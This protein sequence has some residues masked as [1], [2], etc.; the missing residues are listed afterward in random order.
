MVASK[1]EPESVALTDEDLAILSK[2]SPTVVGHVGKVMVVGP[3]LLTDEL[4][5]SLE[6]RIGALPSLTRRLGGPPRAPAWVPDAAF[7]LEDHIVEATSP[8]PLTNADLNQQIAELFAQRLDRSRPLWRIDVLGPLEDGSQVLVWRVHH[9][10]ADGQTAVRFATALL[11]DVAT[12]PAPPASAVRQA[13]ENA[14][15]HHRS[16]RQNLAGF[17]EREFRREG[18]PSPFDGQIGAQRSVA[19]ATVQL[20]PLRR[21]ARSVA[22]ATVND[23]VLACVTGGLRRWMAEGGNEPLQDLRCKVPVSM[24]DASDTLGNRDSFFYL[25]LPLGEPDPAERLRLIRQESAIRKTE[26]DAQEIDRALAALSR[27]SPRLRL[28]CDRF[29]M[30]PRE[31]ALNVSNVPGPR[32][33]VSVVGQPV[34]SIHDLADIAERHALRVAAVS[35]AG[36]LGFGLCADASLIEDLPGLADAIQAEAADLIAIAPPS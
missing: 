12:G 14:E 3:T 16:H 24:H 27:A 22:G 30:D 32:T 11:W 29:L 9:A 18:G 36:Q 26:H 4:R 25:G 20:D 13:T 2:E 21:S 23:A 8:N 17:V 5:A 35:Y 10:L 28:V 6:R 33:P 7:R 19:F 1:S 31:F 34:Q 15:L